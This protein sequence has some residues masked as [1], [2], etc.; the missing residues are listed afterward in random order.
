MADF[1]TPTVVATPPPTASTVYSAPNIQNAVTTPTPAPDLSDPYGLYDQFLKT[2]EIT[3]AQNQLAQTQQAINAS[4]QGLRTTTRALEGQNVQA[5][6]GTGAS[7]NLIGRQVGRARQLTGDELAGLGENL[8]GQQ[9]YLSSLTADAQNRYGIAQQERAQLQDL[10]RQ[11]G[12]KAGITYT[13]SYEQALTKSTKYEE[14]QQERAQLQ[15]I[16]RQTGGQAGIT[17][18]DSYEQALTKATKYEEQQQKKEEEK[19][20]EK[21]KEARERAYKDSIK[22]QLRAMGSST[23]GSINELERKLKKKIKASGA[24]EREMDQLNLAL[25]RKEL[26]KPYYKPD[27]ED[28]FKSTYSAPEQ[29]RMINQALAGGEDWNDIANTFNALGIDTASDSVMDSYL[30]QKF[31]Y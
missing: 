12:G 26:N 25:K 21:E 16:I 10:I 22:A 5:Q 27:G 23:N 31:N 6:G 1:P 28:S 3:T 2:P 4:Q 9:A 7:I 19:M 8:Q 17:Y 11:T 29:R 20:A 13:D 18:K 15:D 24:S 30:K 14:Q